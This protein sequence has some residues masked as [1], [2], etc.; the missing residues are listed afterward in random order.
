M[1]EPNSIIQLY[2][3]GSLAFKLGHKG[4]SGT[5]PNIKIQMLDRSHPATLVIPGYRSSTKTFSL[6]LALQGGLV[7]LFERDTDTKIHVPSSDEEPEELVVKARARNQWFDLK[8]DAREE[9]WTQLLKPGHSYEIRWRDDGKSIW[10]Y[11]GDV[12]QASPEHLPVRCLD[13]SIYV[14]VFDYADTP[15]ELSMSLSPTARVCHLSGE[16]RFGIKFEVISHAEY[17]ITVNLR[18]TP[19]KEWHGLEEVVHVVDKEGQR[20][21]WPWGIGCW[22]HNEPFPSDDMFE[23]LKPGVL[24]EQ[25]FWLEKYDEETANGGELDQLDAGSSYKV[26]VSKTL[27]RVFAIWRKGTK[28]E[29]LAGGEKE[30]EERWNGSSGPVVLEVSDPFTFEAI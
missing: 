5:T 16:P 21:E 18:K 30:K 17:V 13:R 22:E 28:E 24:F 2:L 6:P 15:L 25:T 10:L 20:V 7:D 23:E 3:D 1:T 9:F 8:I 19:I 4:F 14:D 26:D 27:L 12:H 11:R 29:W